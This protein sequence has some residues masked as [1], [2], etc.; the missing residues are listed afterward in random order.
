MEAQLVVDL[1][2]ILRNSFSSSKALHANVK[3]GWKIP[4]RNGY[5][6]LESEDDLTGMPHGQLS[7]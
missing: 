4:N 3:R 5:V 2:K 6:S 1:E 7:P